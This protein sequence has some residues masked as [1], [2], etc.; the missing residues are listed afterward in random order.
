MFDEGRK[1]KCGLAPLPVKLRIDR[2]VD[3][4]GGS[5]AC[6]LWMTN[7]KQAYPQ[8]RIGSRADGTSRHELVSHVVWSL[9]NERSVPDGMCIMHSCDTSR[10]VNPRHLKLG[11]HA[12]NMADKV[13]KGRQYRG[14]A[15]SPARGLGHGRHTKPE[16]TARGARNGA[17]R[18]NDDQVRLIR[19]L[20]E[21][22]RV[23]QAEL[24]TVCDVSTVTISNIWRRRVWEHVA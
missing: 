4:S 18:F 8:I 9:V 22:K 1:S 10:C 5:E 20:L 14:G 6:H 21:E 11:T 12:E 15:V 23:T 17:T 16:K 24:A 2:H 19:Q 3:C 7:P 13:S